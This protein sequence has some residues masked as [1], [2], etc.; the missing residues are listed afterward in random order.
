MRL[1]RF[2]DGDARGADNRPLDRSR[3]AKG[4]L[5]WAMDLALVFIFLPLWA[6]VIILLGLVIKLSDG[7]PIFF[8]R[9]VMGPK[10]SFDAFKLRTMRVDADRWLEQHPDL[11]EEFRKNFKLKQD[12]RVTKFGKFLRKYSLDEL[13]QLLNVM[14]GQM[15]LVGPRMVSPPELE[16]YGPYQ[17]LLLTMKPGITGCWQVSGRQELS[18]E[19]RVKMDV[20]YIQNWSFWLDWKIMCLTVWKVL[21]REGAY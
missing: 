9:R 18:Y 21:K 15:S 4:A 11:L 19:E 16:K 13:P 10:G 2:R 3:K 8:R 6:P 17:A 7:G 14:K 12:P 5:E 1:E 20:Y